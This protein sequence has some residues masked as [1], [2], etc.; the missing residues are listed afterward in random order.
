LKIA[1]PILRK[2]KLIQKG[3]KMTVSEKLA[4]KRIPDKKKPAK[5]I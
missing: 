2:T 1:V 4:A 5:V 3:S